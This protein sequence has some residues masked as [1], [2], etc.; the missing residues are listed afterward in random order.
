M[1]IQRR[2]RRPPFDP[3]AGQH[4]DLQTP[5]VFPYCAMMQVAAE[6]TYTDYVICRGFDIRFGVFIDYEE[7][8]AN[9]PG[10]S[11]AKPFGTRVQ[12]HYQIGQIFPVMLPTQCS[13]QYVPPSPTDVP[14]RVGQ[15]PGT[16][17]GSDGGHPTDLSDAVTELTDHNGNYVNWLMLHDT[18]QY[19]P[20]VRFTADSAFDENDE[21]VSGTIETQYGDG[22]AHTVTTGVFH[23]LLRHDGD[24][25]FEGDED[26]YGLAHFD[27]YEVDDAGTYGPA[28]AVVAHFCICMFECP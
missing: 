28:D 7:G 25:E 17:G 13:G 18:L 9:K 10:I 4:P 2:H 12:S 8:N 22:V 5:G 14:W 24:Y 11:V 27:K 16:T 1:A 3:I 26:D 21:W 23:N 15:N 20:F 19:K 6:D